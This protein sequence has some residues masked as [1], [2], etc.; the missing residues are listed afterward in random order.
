[1]EAGQV[2]GGDGGRPGGGQEACRVLDPLSAW[3]LKV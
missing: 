2:G 1:M 3:P